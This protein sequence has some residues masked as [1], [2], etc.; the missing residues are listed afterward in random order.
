M[1]WYAMLLVVAVSIAA[2]DPAVN[3]DQKDLQGTWKVTSAE[4]NGDALDRIVDNTLAIDGEKFTI[5][6]KTSDLK[7]TFELHTGIM[8]KG[9]DFKHDEGAVKGET[10]YAN[11][12]LDGDELKICYK[13]PNPDK[14]R[15]GG[16][17]TT[18]GSNLLCV[19]LERVKP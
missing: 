15:P 19:K 16:F 10:W 11:Y 5:K 4:Q 17:T 1:K 7:G 6:T 9:M 14:L 18:A 13:D 8:P 2:D 12:S 3:T